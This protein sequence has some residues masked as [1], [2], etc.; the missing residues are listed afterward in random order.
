MSC[1]PARSVGAC[2]RLSSMPICASFSNRFRQ[3]AV[4]LKV[5]WWHWLHHRLSKHSS[6][7]SLWTIWY[8]NFGTPDALV[9]QLMLADVRCRK[10][11][12]RLMQSRMLSFD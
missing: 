2:R 12:R 6:W 3:P 8:D 9:V 1:S 10:R 11:T 7:R 5:D 4:Y